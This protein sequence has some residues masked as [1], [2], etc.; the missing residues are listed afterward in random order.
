LTNGAKMRY[1]L[2]VC[3]IASGR[4]GARSTAR[5]RF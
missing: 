1:K 2:K 3:Q 5:E 4:L